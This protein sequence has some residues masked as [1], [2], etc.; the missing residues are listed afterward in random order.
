MRLASVELLDSDGQEI[1][2]AIKRVLSVNEPSKVNNAKSADPGK[3]TGFTPAFPGAVE[4]QQ[5]Q[6]DLHNQREDIKRI[7]TN[8]FR[9]VSALDKRADRIDGEVI[10][11][12]GTVGGVH[13]GVGDL[14][15][16]LGSIKGEIGKVRASAQ[17]TSALVKLDTRLTAASNTLGEVGQQVTAL[18]NQ[19]QE[20]IG[21]LKSELRRQQQDIEDLRS[22]VRDGVTAADYARDMADLRTEIAHLRQELDETRAHGI[23]RV[24]TAFTP[25]ELEVLTS[26]I[27]KIGNRAS[28]VETL[29]MELE[30]LKGRV[31]RGEA[32]RQTAGN[33]RPSRTIDA[34]G[35][36]GYSDIFPATR[37]R[38]A[39]PGIDP[40]PKRPASSA[41]YTNFPNQR[42]ATP[43]S[44][45]TNQ[46]TTANQGE[47]PED[48]ISHIANSAKRGPRGHTTATP[49]GISA[50]LRKR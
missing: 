7:D 17:D 38:A 35:L 49:T 31:E 14:Q 28:Q 41:G 39:S 5:F 44:W 29:Q 48:D 34:G 50:R 37:K 10:R 33:R 16:E 22:E 27:A 21:G 12:K 13:R 32:S 18:N 2:F 20:E 36:P 46:P 43:P 47:A 3:G 42:Y 26:N 25:R 6:I 9:I 11:L 4:L 15:R 45:P 40:I 24:E 30:I 23:G 1:E 8:G 19:L